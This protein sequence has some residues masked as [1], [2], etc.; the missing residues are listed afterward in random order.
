[1]KERIKILV[2]DDDRRMVKTICDILTIK[3]YEAIAAYS[4][5]EALEKVSSEAP[6]CVL[7][8]LK[9][10]GI[11]GVETLARI[12]VISPGLPV[13]LMSAYASEEKTEEAKQQ[14]AY[15]VLAKPI[16]IQQV[17]SFLSILRKEE[18][19][20]IVDDDPT[21]CKTLRDILQTR[22]YRVETETEA[23]KVLEHMEQDYK[24][25]VILDLKLGNDNGVDVLMNIRQR[26]PTKPV[27][28]VTGYREGMTS[29]IENGI[30]IGAH[31]CLYKPFA[32]EE[33]IEVIED[34]SKRKLKAVLG[35]SF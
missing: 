24:L 1:M 19:I 8:D 35:E 33:L 6:D 26:Y 25:L 23:E 18:S 3:K 9:M 32:T 22:G 21:F 15:A 10:P 31:T 7:M 20:L 12:R 16:D 4:G 27:V 13:V 5:E 17:L 28:M 34:I 29:S 11:D 30:R 2:V 14:G